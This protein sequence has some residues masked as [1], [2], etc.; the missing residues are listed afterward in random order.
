M[1]KRDSRSAVVG[2]V[3]GVAVGVAVGVEVTA[4]ACKFSRRG[5]A[6]GVGAGAVTASST[7]EAIKAAAPVGRTASVVVA[8]AAAAVYV[9]TGVAATR[10]RRPAMALFLGCQD[11][12]HAGSDEVSTNRLLPI[13]AGCLGRGEGA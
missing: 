3:R 6:G 2:G 12:R 5:V 11:G 1:A 4:V 13:N 10:G 9:S 8:V 7:V